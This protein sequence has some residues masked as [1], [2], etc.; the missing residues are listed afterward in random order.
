MEI[1]KKIGNELTKTITVTKN[2]DYKLGQISIIFY[3]CTIQ[4]IRDWEPCCN[5]YKYSTIV[6]NQSV[7]HKAITV[8]SPT[9]ESV[10]ITMIRDR[11]KQRFKILLEKNLIFE[12]IYV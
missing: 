7:K 8:F 2:F 5:K 12:S 9:L 1:L 3:G 10:K 4:I 11:H 6:E